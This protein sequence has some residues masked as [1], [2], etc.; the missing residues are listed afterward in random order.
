MAK[1]GQREAEI[2]GGKNVK[3][4]RKKILF[5]LAS[6]MLQSLGMISG[7]LEEDMVLGQLFSATAAT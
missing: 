6:R 1:L 3:A 7:I 4:E 5:R 2:P